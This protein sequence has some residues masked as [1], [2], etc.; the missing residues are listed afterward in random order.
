MGYILDIMQLLIEEIGKEEGLKEGPNVF[1]LAPDRMKALVQEEDAPE[2]K[3]AGDAYTAFGIEV[4]VR[5]DY[6][7]GLITL[8]RPPG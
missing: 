6:P 7:F 1:Q 4:R 2:L 8:G 3:Q 5:D